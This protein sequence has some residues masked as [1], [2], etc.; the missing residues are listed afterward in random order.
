MVQTHHLFS[1]TKLNKKL[2]GKLIDDP[3]NIKYLCEKCHLWSVIPKLNENEF[4]E[5]LGIPARSKTA[6]LIEKAKHG[7]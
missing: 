6:Q 5:M 4:C 7:K 3:R 1:Q 2:Y